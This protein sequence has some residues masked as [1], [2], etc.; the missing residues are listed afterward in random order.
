LKAEGDP[1]KKIKIADYYLEAE[2]NFSVCNPLFE[3]PSHTALTQC[4]FNTFNVS[5]LP[6]PNLSKNKPN[7]NLFDYPRKTNN[8]E[9]WKMIISEDHQ[10]SKLNTSS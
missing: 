9:L 8:N 6:D 10:S 7:C 4:L 2:K 1:A 3:R 5:A